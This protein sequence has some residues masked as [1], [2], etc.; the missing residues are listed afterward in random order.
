MTHDQ[1]MGTRKEAH[2][3]TMR[4]IFGDVFPIIIDF[5]EPCCHVG[6]IYIY[7]CEACFRVSE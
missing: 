5:M 3:G 4:T 6:T 7:K 2:M 1:P